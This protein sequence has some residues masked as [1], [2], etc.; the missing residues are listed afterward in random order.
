M[1]TE[2][3]GMKGFEGQYMTKLQCDELLKTAKETHYN[4]KFMFLRSHNGF[5]NGKL[6]LLLGASSGGKSTVVRSLLFEVLSATP[7]GKKVL[8]WLSEESLNDFKTELHKTGI[9]EKGKPLLEKLLLF[10][11]QEYIGKSPQEF[12]SKLGKYA[13]SG[14]IS[15]IFFDNMTTSK[16]YADMHPTMQV[17]VMGFLKSITQRNNIATLLVAHTG[18]TVRG[19]AK[20][21]ID[22]NDIRGSK[23]PVNMV[24][25]LYVLQTVQVR[26]RMIVTVAIQK[27][28]G[29]DI[30]GKYYQLRYEKRLMLYIGDF[31]LEFED[32]KQL[33]K[34]ANKL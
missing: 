12:Q 19:G 11:E 32:L 9:I 24:E 16:I 3:E 8:V 2:N 28:R 4:S 23:S 5:R 31:H 14:E 21:L 17:N 7:K 22:M 10:S 20:Q 27:H 33:H 26:D 30:S 15:F 1:E 34:D 29:Q 13:D 18:A 6:H 25:F